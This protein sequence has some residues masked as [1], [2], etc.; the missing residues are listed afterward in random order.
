MAI[1]FLNFKNIGRMLY[2]LKYENYIRAYSKEYNVDPMLVAAV[3]RAESNYKAEA[4]SSKDAY[5]L[6]QITPETAKWSAE[7]M[8]LENFK[9]EDLYKP[10]TNIKIGCWYLDNLN[11]E[12][13]GNT[14][15]VLAAYNGGRG[16]VRKWLKESDHS[17]DGVNLHYIPFP[18]T[19][20]YVKKVKVNYNIYKY[21]YGRDDQKNKA[22]ERK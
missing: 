13:G 7:K 22:S 14:D 3:I 19:D 9:V 10:E 21:L 6:M 8:K 5:G 12:F 1:A 16:N 11:A 18:E 20:K 15:L 2:P 4:K 17:K